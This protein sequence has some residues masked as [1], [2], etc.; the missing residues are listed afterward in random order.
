MARRPDPP[1][2]VLGAVLAICGVFH[3]SEKIG[4]TADEL[5]IVL[6]S[7]ATIGAVLRYRFE[8]RGADG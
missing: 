8:N 7:L 6:G 1:A 2:A 3:V 5:G 4:I